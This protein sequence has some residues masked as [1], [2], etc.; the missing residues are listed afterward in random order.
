MPRTGVA[1]IH[2]WHGH[3]EVTEADD[4]GICNVVWGSISACQGPGL[5]EYARCWILAS[6]ASGSS[7]EGVTSPGCHQ[8]TGVSL[9]TGGTSGA[10]DPPGF[11]D[12]VNGTRSLVTS[13]QHHRFNHDASKSEQA[14]DLP[15]DRELQ[16]EREHDQ[17]HACRD[18]DDWH[19]VPYARQNAI[20]RCSV[21]KGDP[22]RR[23]V[24]PRG[25]PAGGQNRG[26]EKRQSDNCAPDPLAAPDTDSRRR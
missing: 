20:E 26:C 21:S 14:R 6:S 11:A 19:R 18:Q 12:W 25:C 2:V 3:V 15:K 9:T 22:Q 24:V 1:D 8:T 10:T 4:R 13:S 23:V 5:A 7:P 17:D 16:E